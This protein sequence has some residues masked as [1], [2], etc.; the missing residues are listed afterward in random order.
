MVAVQVVVAVP[1]Q[2]GGRRAHGDGYECTGR[3]FTHMLNDL[4][5]GSAS[6]SG[7]VEVSVVESRS[8][9]ARRVAPC[10]AAG[11][12]REAPE[13]MSE[14]TVLNAVVPFRVV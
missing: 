8:G 6:N 14:S 1:G 11:V 4:L 9:A 5:R 13:W 10:R 3:P 12:R 7:E 2:D